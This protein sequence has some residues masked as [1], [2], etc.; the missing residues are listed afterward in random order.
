MLK[1]TGEITHCYEVTVDAYCLTPTIETA[2]HD[3]TR[4]EKGYLGEDQSAPYLHML[5]E[6]IECQSV[7]CFQGSAV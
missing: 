6:P 3:A 2:L 1:W 4:D 7:E 5:K